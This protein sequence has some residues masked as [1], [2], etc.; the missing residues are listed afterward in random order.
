MP[1]LEILTQPT[2]YWSIRNIAALLAKQ[3]AFTMVD[4]GGGGKS[5]ADWY[6]ALTPFGRTPAL[7]HDGRV[8]VES[9]LINEY[10]DETFADPPLLP[11]GAFARSWAR[12]WMSHCDNTLIPLLSRIARA[13]T[14]DARAGEL[15]DLARQLDRAERGLFRDAA[16]HGDFYGGAAPGLVDFAWHTFFA[17]V[18]RTP[19]APILLPPRLAAWAVALAAHPLL[20]TA[21]T[22]LAALHAGEAA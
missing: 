8:I 9:L 20:R 2:C 14:D 18:T 11:A 17:A 3:V 22:R 12:I 21:E 13:G 1:T 15:A 19:S 10:I 6:M 16:P 4:V 5:K 7:R